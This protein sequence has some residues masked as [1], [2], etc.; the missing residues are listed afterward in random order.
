MS[1]HIKRIE[2]ADAAYEAMVALRDEV[3]RK[4]LGLSIKN[5]DLTQDIPDIKLV[6]LDGEQVVGCLMLKRRSTTTLKLRA[7]AVSP[8]LQKAGV[9]KL[10]V[11]AAERTA[12]E[13]GYTTIELHARIVAR[14]FYERLGYEV[15]GDEFTE[16]G[17]PHLRMKKELHELL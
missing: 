2:V 16:V 8:T 5:D 6:A 3:L 15:E 17:I 14:G 11:A 7:M 10:L 13:E 9:G 4:P 1:L 12:L